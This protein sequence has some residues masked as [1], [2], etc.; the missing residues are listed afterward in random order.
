LLLEEASLPVG[1][2]AAWREVRGLVLGLMLLCGLGLMLRQ[3]AVGMVAAGLLLA[4]FYFFRDP[5]R[6]P[7]HPTEPL[8]LAPAD[9][10]VQAIDV[11]AEERFLQGPA[12]RLTIFLSLAN[13]HV[14]RAACAGDVRLIHYQAGGFVPAFW[15]RAERNET[16]FVGI[17]TAHGPLVIAQICGILARRI[18]CW[19]K[20]GD[21]LAQGERLGLIKFGSRVDLYLP[22]QCELLVGVGQR[23]YGG[24]TPVARWV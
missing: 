18:V 23:V 17:M 15:R 16:N 9:G 3:R 21:R 11:V 20:V 1:I 24:Q 7:A 12:R 10:R 13:V 22:L 4:V 8:V 19:V 5:E 2:S 14:Q 6:A